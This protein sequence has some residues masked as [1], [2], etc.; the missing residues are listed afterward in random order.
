MR[1]MNPTNLLVAHEHGITTVTL[2][3]PDKANTLDTSIASSLHAALAE[4]DPKATRLLVIRGEGRHFC[5]GF[6][7]SGLAETTDEQILER[8][9]LIESML[10]RLHHLPVPTL[11]LVHGGAYGAG[12]DVAV[13]CDRVIADPAAKAR[14]PG[15]RFG[16]QLGTRRLAA[17]IGS[18]SALQL[19]ATAEVVAAERALSLGLFDELLPQTAWESRVAAYTRELAI[20]PAAHARLKRVIKADTRSEDMQD[21]IASVAESPSIKSRVEAYVATLNKAG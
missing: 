14:F 8:L 4:V 9:T 11:A 13:A 5:A 7:F 10:Q 6:D 17:R 18:R 20:A 16:L 2:N 3:R 19:L 12:C 1:G 15:W 21:M